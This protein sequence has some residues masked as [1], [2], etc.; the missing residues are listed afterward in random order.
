MAQLEE[1]VKF[2]RNDLVLTTQLAALL[3][4]LYLDGEEMPPHRESVGGPDTSQVTAPSLR[5]LLQ[6]CRA[7]CAY[8]DL[9]VRLHI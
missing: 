3:S 9:K 1:E 5:L 6:W 7:V 2:L 4:D 8:Y